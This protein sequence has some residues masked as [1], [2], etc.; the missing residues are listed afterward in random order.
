[1]W[2][3]VVNAWR[4]LYEG[5]A[6]EVTLPGEDGE[7]GVMDFHQPMLYRLRQGYIQITKPAPGGPVTR[8]LIHDGIAKMVGNKLVLLVESSTNPQTGWMA[9]A[10]LSL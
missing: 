5:N 4:S 8:I 6:R 10:G 7:V 3:S 1:M 2:V 9:K